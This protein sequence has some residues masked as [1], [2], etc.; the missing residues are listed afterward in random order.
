MKRDSP[1]PMP[2]N[3]YQP[4][5]GTET[6]GAEVVIGTAAVFLSAAICLVGLGPMAA[7]MVVSSQ[8][9]EDGVQPG[10]SELIGSW[11]A[12]A[13]SAPYILCVVGGLALMAASFWFLSRRRT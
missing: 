1:K 3:P 8:L 4:P 13:F 12:W 7:A 5:Q 2:E 11:D 6:K 9:L 10:D